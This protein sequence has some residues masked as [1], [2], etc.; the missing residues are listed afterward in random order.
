MHLGDP[1]RTAAHYFNR[2]LA[3]V[4][5]DRPHPVKTWVTIQEDLRRRV[6][7]VGRENL[8][9]RYKYVFPKYYL[10][11]SYINEALYIAIFYK[12]L[13]FFV[14]Y[15]RITFKDVNFFKHKFLIYFLRAVFN[16][17]NMVTNQLAGTRGLFVKFRGKVSQAGNSRKKRFLVGCGQISTSQSA[18]YEIEKFQ[19]KTFTGAIG[20]TIILSSE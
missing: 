1:Y 18:T 11:H 12:D 7:N 19:I 2:F 6:L 4:L 9:V 10:R 8:L 3:C 20:C 15:L 14:H 5:H 17:L 13:R 16:N